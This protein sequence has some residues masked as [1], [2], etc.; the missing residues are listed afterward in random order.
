MTNVG[1]IVGCVSERGLLNISNS[2]VNA[3]LCG[4]RKVGGA[5]GRLE[6]TNTNLNAISSST[7]EVTITGRN[8]VDNTDDKFAGVV[9]YLGNG[10]L[11]VT[12]LTV[13]GTIT[14]G[15]GFHVAGIV[16]SV[17]GATTELNID[18]VTVDMD[19]FGYRTVAGIVGLV[20]APIT[21]QN[22]TVAGTYEAS[23]GS[24][25]GQGINT[26]YV[27]GIIGQY[28]AA[29]TSAISNVK[30]DADLTAYHEA[31]G[32]IAGGLSATGGRID[33]TDAT[34]SGTIIGSFRVGGFV[35]YMTVGTTLNVTDSQFIGG[36]QN[37]PDDLYY[38]NI[39]TYTNGNSEQV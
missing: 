18:T 31:I 36:I 16:G 27:G 2:T 30:V 22:A 8:Y 23:T 9:G 28:A 34:V 19:L 32:G 38:R 25:E 29:A 14:A 17:S 7:F 15:D 37:Q 21:V 3:T 1:G 13:E 10:K 26:S 33:I 20:Q 35:G 4:R 39:I 5:V 6:T 12:N 24:T 11:D